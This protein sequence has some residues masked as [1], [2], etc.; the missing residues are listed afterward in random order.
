MVG[1]N[2][3][4]P[5][6]RGPAEGACRVGRPAAVKGRSSSHEFPCAALL[7]ERDAMKVCRLWTR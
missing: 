4:M 5:K 2:T 7:S 6:S 3:R 1:A